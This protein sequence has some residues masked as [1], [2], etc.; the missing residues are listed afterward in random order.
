[1][2]IKNFKSLQKTNIIGDEN[3][4]VSGIA[5]DSREVKTGDIFVAI[6]GTKI[7]G[8]K[9]IDKA[10]ENGAVA[11]VLQKTSSYKNEK[12]TKIYVENPRKTLAFL[13]QELYPKRPKIITA[14]TGTNGKTSIADFTKQFFEMLGSSSASFGTLGFDTTDKSIKKIEIKEIT[15]PNPLTF[16]KILD[17]L[18]ENK[19]ESLCFEA[20]S[21]AMIQARIEG[22]QRKINCIGFT[23]LTPDH[24]SEHGTMENYFNAKASLFFDYLADDGIAVINADDSYGKKLISQLN[25]QSVLSYGKNG[26]Y[27]KV[28]KNTPKDTTQSVIIEIFG[29]ALKIELPLIGAFQLHNALCAFGLMLGGFYGRKIFK[30]DFWQDYRLAQFRGF[31]QK[32]KPVRGRLEYVGKTKKG[33]TVFVDYAHT[34]DAMENVLGA[35]RPHTEGKLTIIFGIGGGRHERQNMGKTANDFADKIVLTDDNP[36]E[37]DPKFLR[38]LVKKNIQNKDKLLEIPDREEAIKTAILESQNGDCIVIAGKGHETYQEIKGKKTHFDD[39]E[40]AEGYMK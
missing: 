2:K 29:R 39:R 17:S 4:E 36:R 38:E 10:I 3:M 14:I 21:T 18:A 32:L 33:A 23:N 8:E 16:Y 40:I 31:L 13:S 30:K 7:N 1:M 27:F 11:I 12:I 6:Q 5:F 24:L 9:F 26:E 35:L 20:S 25:P 28:L 22:M 34:F 19:V 37:D 15:S